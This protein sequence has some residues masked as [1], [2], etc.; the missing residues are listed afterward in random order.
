MS[1]DSEELALLTARAGIGR[2][3]CMRCGYAPKAYD[4]KPDGSGQIIWN[5]PAPP[6]G[7]PD[8]TPSTWTTVRE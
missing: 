7:D 1:I 4:M 5:R 8:D 6:D 3:G 2:A